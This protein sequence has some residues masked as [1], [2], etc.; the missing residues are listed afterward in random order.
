MNRRI[1][2]FATASAVLYLAGG[3]LAADNWKEW[4]NDEYGIRMTIPDKMVLAGKK[5]E[6]GWGGLFGKLGLVEMFVIGKLGK[7]HSLQDMQ[8]FGI[9]VS[10]VPAKHWNKI[11][12]GE[13][14][15]GWKWYKTYRADGPKRA[16]FAILA[17]NEKG[18][19]I[20]FLRTTRANLRRNLKAYVQWYQSI[21]AI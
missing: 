19:F 15:N 21:T 16:L 1:A 11:D 2:I 5:F 8:A 6:Q 10:G 4:K 13:G 20:I 7:A 17:Q 3:A 12:E 14:D 9:T 18:S